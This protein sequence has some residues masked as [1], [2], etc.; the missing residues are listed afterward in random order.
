MSICKLV[1]CLLYLSHCY[2]L[3]KH[4]HIG[5]F[6]FNGVF[7]DD[8]HSKRLVGRVFF[9][10]CQF[11]ATNGFFGGNVNFFLDPASSQIQCFAFISI[12][13]QLPNGIH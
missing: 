2:F 3:G 5:P 11:E 7:M 4:K 6:W 8:S 12:N 10:T 1:S 13:D 9:S